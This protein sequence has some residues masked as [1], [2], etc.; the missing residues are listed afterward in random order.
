VKENE[1]S[2]EIE[3]VVKMYESIGVFKERWL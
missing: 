3:I 1:T 2:Y